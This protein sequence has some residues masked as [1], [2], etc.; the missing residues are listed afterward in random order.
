MQIRLLAAANLQFLSLVRLYEC[1][2]IFKN[3]HNYKLNKSSEEFKNT[4]AIV[5]YR[6]HGL[7]LSAAN[8]N[9]N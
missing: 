9:I 2:E 6:Q 5:N 3:N 4:V 8:N 7:N 1:S